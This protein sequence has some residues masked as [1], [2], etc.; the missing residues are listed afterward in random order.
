[1]K[2]N[3]EIHCLPDTSAGEGREKQP[4]RLGSPWALTADRPEQQALA[5][6]CASMTKEK[7]NTKSR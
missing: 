3:D 7:T 1:M 2:K 4:R 6:I 5:G